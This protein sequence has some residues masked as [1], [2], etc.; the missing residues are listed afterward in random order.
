MQKCRFAGELSPKVQPVMPKCIVFR[1][2]FGGLTLTA[3]EVD[4]EG[5]NVDEEKKMCFPLEHW[6][7]LPSHLS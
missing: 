5:A 3:L 2:G 4:L 7:I 1:M 6:G